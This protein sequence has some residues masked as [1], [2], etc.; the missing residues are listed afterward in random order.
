M[1]IL[2]VLIKMKGGVGRANTEIAASL[3]K[4][5]HE[6]DLLSREDDLNIFSLSKSIFP[7]RKKIKTLMKEKNYDFIYTQD[8]SCALPLL[9][10]YLLFW[11]KHFSCFCGCKIGLWQWPQILL[12]IIVGKI[13]GKKLIVIGDSLKERFPRSKKIYRGVNIEK[14][15]PL[16]KK[17]KFIGWIPKTYE[18]ISDSE[19]MQ[20]SN[21][22]G[23]K[24]MKA[25]NIAPE[26]MNEFYNQCKVFVD[27]PLTAG[28]NLAW[29]EAMSAGVPIIVGNKNG[30]GRF[31]P[32][33]KINSVEDN[34]KITEYIN[35]QRKRNYR[36]WVIENNFS[37]DAKTEELIDYFKKMKKN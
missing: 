24:I 2:I 9:F 12:Q 13:F 36:K 31:L 8:Y 22:T 20:I 4:K 7:L 16:N 30:A 23:L 5:G 1:K 17:R 33:D 14:F 35:N 18:G 29:L 19:L 6:V 21:E 32:I 25:E 28:F 26:K 10:P 27:L 3:R 37:W 15:K 11:K 34:K